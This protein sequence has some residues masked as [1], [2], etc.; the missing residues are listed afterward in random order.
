MESVWSFTFDGWT[1]KNPR[2]DLIISLTLQFVCIVSYEV[3]KKQDPNCG[4]S[5]EMQRK[6]ARGLTLQRKQDVHSQIVNPE[7]FPDGTSG[8]QKG[9]E[10]QIKL[11]TDEGKKEDSGTHLFGQQGDEVSLKLRLDHLH[12]MLDL[13][14]LTAVNQLIQRQQLLGPSPALKSKW[15]R[16]CFLK[17]VI[18]YNV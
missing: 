12:H 8:Q 7:G 3:E 14:G 17:M 10:L 11:L 18:L 1:C 15:Q 9:W 16:N 13:C 2:C 5:W 6:A 4:L